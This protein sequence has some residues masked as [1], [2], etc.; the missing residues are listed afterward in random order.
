MNKCDLNRCAGGR[1]QTNTKRNYS[2]I[3]DNED[4]P[5]FPQI[6]LHDYY[7]HIVKLKK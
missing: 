1:S 4:I 7:Q 5:S 6:L 3:Q 2:D